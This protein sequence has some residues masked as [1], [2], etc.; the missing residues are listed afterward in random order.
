MDAGERSFGAAERETLAEARVSPEDLR[1]ARKDLSEVV[2]EGRSVSAEVAD[3]LEKIRQ[4]KSPLTAAE[5]KIRGLR[6]ALDN[7]L[8]KADALT[9][10]DRH[11]LDE[12]EDLDLSIEA[13]SSPGGATVFGGVAPGREVPALNRSVYNKAM[14]SVDDITR[15]MDA[16]SDEAQ[17]LSVKVDAL[18]ERG[19]VLKSLDSANRESFNVARRKERQEIE[20]SRILGA[21][22]REVR[23]LRR[24]QAR[25]FRELTGAEQ[26]A[27][28]TAGRADATNEKILDL[29]AQLESAETAWRTELV[30]SRQIPEGYALTGMEGL[31]GVSF[32]ETMSNAVNAI[33]EGE[34]PT[35][36]KAKGVMRALTSFNQMYR[37]VRATFDNSAL[38]IQ[39]WAALARDKKGTLPA[40]HANFDVWMG[41]HG[42]RVFG[43]FANEQDALARETGE[44]T[45]A[46]MARY[47]RVRFGGDETEYTVRGALS[48]VPGVKRSN[49]A[50][51]VTGDV[52]RHT[53]FKSEM[54]SEFAKGR[55]KG[56]IIASGD[57]ERAGLAINNGTGWSEYRTGGD[58]GELTFFAARFLQSRLET[59]ARAG[60][61]LRPGATLDQRIARGAMGNLIWQ[62]TAATIVINKLLGNDTDFRPMVNGHKNSNFMR[63][64]VGGRDYSMFGTWDS[65]VGMGIMVAA[66]DAPDALRGMSSGAVTNAWD[67]L[68]G[69]SAIG[70]DIPRI[71]RPDEIAADP[72]AFVLRLTENLLPFSADELLSLGGE[73]VEAAYE[74][75]F[76]APGVAAGLGAAAAELTGIK[77]SRLSLGDLEDEAFKALTPEPWQGKRVRLE[78]ATADQIIEVRAIPEIAEKIKK[79][80]EQ[81][82]LTPILEDLRTKQEMLD[83]QFLSGEISFGQWR[84]GTNGYFHESLGARRIEFGDEKPFKTPDN[85]Y[86]EYINLTWEHRDK[87]GEP[88]W[89]EIDREMADWKQADLDFVAA[90]S[91]VNDTQFQGFRRDISQKLDPLKFFDRY[92]DAWAIVHGV[93]VRQPDVDEL[94]GIAA[95]NPDF[96]D[97]MRAAKDHYLDLLPAS[98]S[99]EE[100]GKQAAEALNSHPLIKKHRDERNRIES[101]LVAAEPQTMFNAMRAGY[102]SPSPDERAFLEQARQTRLGLSAAH[103][104][105]QPQPVLAQ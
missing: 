89:E 25:R 72:R 18:I 51:G 14:D 79:R 5:K 62:G 70:E 97:F 57:A 20:R 92:D 39:L 55:T 61:G 50:F 10:P 66:G 71:F 38:G 77:S 80:N 74:G 95:K 9:A 28:N 4:A 53:W 21:A 33:L 40:L 103:P 78:N 3:N 37:G 102:F 6:T 27:A 46:E 93:A 41:R 29:E 42:E 22:K 1:E 49:R 63:I 31:E 69:E 12:F 13:R 87:L 34:G 99:T 105:E 48:R 2:S 76:S 98:M 8:N 36:G 60:M 58:L 17:E 43:K 104:S 59:V 101:T 19:D 24:E 54:K 86:E 90:R 15:Q 82:D 7:A 94:F 52:R 68:S 16:L 88:R 30:K 100:K 32:P 64:R 83:N 81:S 84:S 45:T 65:L 73:G 35:T 23:I 67:F 47:G 75:N 44:F 85:A 26:R 11:W 91:G 96:D 56:E